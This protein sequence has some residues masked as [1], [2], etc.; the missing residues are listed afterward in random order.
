MRTR[1]LVSACLAGLHCRYN[2]ETTPC[3]PVVRLIREGRAVPFCPEVHG[4]LTTPRHPCEIKDGRVVDT[5]GA[6][7]TDAFRLGAQEGLKLARMAGCDQAILKSRSPSCGIGTIYDGTF[8]GTPVAGD[9][10][11]AALL[12][13]HGITVRSELDFEDA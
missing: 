11:F 2:G 5:E 4:G 9:G 8:S 6:D 1:Y 13:D 7:H 10:L 3:E 12:R